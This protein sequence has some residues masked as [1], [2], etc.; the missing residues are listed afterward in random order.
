MMLVIP[1]PQYEKLQC[2]VG[3]EIEQTEYYV[4]LE[5]L[6][7]YLTSVSLGFLIL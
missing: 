2:V 7:S 1:C 6:Q 5:K 4:I 3:F